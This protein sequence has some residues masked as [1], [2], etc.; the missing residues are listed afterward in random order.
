MTLFQAPLLTD[1]AVHPAQQFRM[2]ISDLARGNSGITQA[3]DLKVY[4]QS[5]T[6]N[7][8]VLIGAGSG[9][10][11][12]PLGTFGGA[13][14][15]CNVG[16]D[17]VDIAPTGATPRSDMV[18]LRIE[19]PEYNGD[20]DPATDPI[21]YFDVATNVGSTATQ[22]P[23]GYVGIPLARIDIPA[24]TAVITSGMIH[25][26]RQVANPRRERT[27]RTFSPATGPV[28]LS[29]TSGV[30]TYWSNVPGWNIDVPLWATTARIVIT[31][32]QLKY[33]GADVYGDFG[34]TFGSSL[35]L[36]DVL[37]FDQESGTRR[38]TVVCA[39]TLTLPDAY[40]GTT[41]LL[42]PRGLMKSPNAGTAGMDTAVSLVADVEFEE[43]P[44]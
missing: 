23:F 6:P 38:G 22:V 31:V 40:R 19:D 37:M 2:M 4:A 42:R 25:D 1:G 29:G 13:Y 27:L 18:I 3:T 11:Q 28:E 17:S 12:T 8:S 43:A 16:S 39:D 5:P 9:T 7:G 33:A 41:Q 15:V 24:S 34:A 21:M 10:V 26:L 20:L 30:Y 36:Q 32:C 35:A 44:I 14:S